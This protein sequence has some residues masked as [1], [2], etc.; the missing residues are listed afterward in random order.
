[1]D[2]PEK[3]PNETTDETESSFIAG[4]VARNEASVPDENGNLPP[5]VTHE[6]VGQKPDGTPVLV[7][8]RFSSF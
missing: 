8:R 3:N 4:V 2:Q 6:I 5:G 1:M 7:R